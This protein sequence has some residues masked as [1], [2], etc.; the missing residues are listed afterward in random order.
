MTTAELDPRYDIAK[1][2]SGLVRRRRVQR[3]VAVAAMLSAVLACAVLFLVLWARG[4]GNAPYV[5]ITTTEFASKES[6]ERA[7]EVSKTRKNWVGLIADAY[8]VEK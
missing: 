4:N 3:A 1:S 7:I 5:N 8:C 6:C 2:S